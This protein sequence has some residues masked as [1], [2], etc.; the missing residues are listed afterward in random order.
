M[1]L[2]TPPP[3]TYPSTTIPIDV[4]LPL[5]VLEQLNEKDED[6]DDDEDDAQT[7]NIQTAEGQVSFRKAGLQRQKSSTS[8]RSLSR[9]TS[10]DEQSPAKSGE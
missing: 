6:N 3:A 5:P 9:T 2:Q 7:V 4:K 1:L 10:A 8:T